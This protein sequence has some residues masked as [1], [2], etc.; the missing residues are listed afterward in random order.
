[1]RRRRFWW[2]SS[3]DV[4]EMGEIAERA[5]DFERLRNGKVVEQCDELLAHRGASS[6]TARRKRTA[7]WR[8]AS[9]RA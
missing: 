7:V 2:T 1:M 4:D 8:M 9:M 6:S 5:D 3:G